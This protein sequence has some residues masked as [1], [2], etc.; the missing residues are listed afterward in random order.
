MEEA[1]REAGLWRLRRVVVG[2]ELEREREG[3]PGPLGA[4]FPGEPAVPLAEVDGAVGFGF[5]WVGLGLFW[6]EGN[7]G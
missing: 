6:G 2:R 1:R 3:A 4:L 5:G 7:G